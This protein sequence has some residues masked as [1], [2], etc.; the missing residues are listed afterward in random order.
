MQEDPSTCLFF[1]GVVVVFC[2]SIIVCSVDLCQSLFMVRV[3]MTV[4]GVDMK[5]IGVVTVM[6]Q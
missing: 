6:S 2:A 5:V 4:V 3:D 1:W